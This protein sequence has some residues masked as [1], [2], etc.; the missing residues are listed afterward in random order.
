MNDKYVLTIY[1]ALLCLLKTLYKVQIKTH[2]M[3]LKSP[4]FSQPTHLCSH[5]KDFPPIYRKP[6]TA[7]FSPSHWISL[8]PIWF[9]GLPRSLPNA[10]QYRSKSK[11]W[12]VMPINS[13][14]FLSML[15]YRQWSTL[16]GIDRRWDQWHNFD[17]YWLALIG[18]WPGFSNHESFIET[19]EE[20]HDHFYLGCLP[21]IM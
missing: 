18:I 5:K 7:G 16:R 12:S 4:V 8:A 3:I 10:D 21:P 9:S 17:W 13:C 6:L 19:H 15:I 1:N 14:Q 20:I 11:Y 2:G